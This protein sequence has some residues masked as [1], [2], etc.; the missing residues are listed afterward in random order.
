MNEFIIVANPLS[1]AILNRW[2]LRH[3]IKPNIYLFKN[4]EL[5]LIIN[6]KSRKTNQ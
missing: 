1:N 5:R 6:N 3:K 4:K 2:N